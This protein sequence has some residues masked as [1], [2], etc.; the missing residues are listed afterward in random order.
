MYNLNEVIE[1][2]LEELLKDREALALRNTTLAEAYHQK[3][4]KH[5]MRRLLLNFLAGVYVP[6]TRKATQTNRIL[7]IRPDHLGDLLL[8][9]PAIQALRSHLPDAEIHALVGP[10]AADVLTNYDEIDLVLTIP[11]PGFTRGQQTNWRSPYQYALQTAQRLRRIGYAKAIVF[12]PDH[13]W[14][15]WLAK[16]A[17][18]PVRVGYDD[19]DTKLFLT[20]ELAHQH[21]HAVKQNMRLVEALIGTSLSTHQAPLNYPV[22]DVDTAYITGYLSE[23]NIH[24][25]QPI[26]CIHPGSGTK[27]KQWQATKWAEVATILTEQF[28]A[29]VVFTG[30]D[31]ELP[32]IQEITRHMA[33][34]AI[35]IAG[36]TNVGQ[37]AALYQRSKVVLGPDSGPLHVA[38]GVGTP[39]VTLY[40][41]AD[42]VEFGSWGDPQRHITLHTNIACRP[43]RILD[44]SSDDIRYHPCVQDITVTQ[45]LTAARNAAAHSN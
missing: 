22:V 27:V 31:S 2:P 25:E 29:T 13:W 7:L 37:L 35:V 24:K 20:H 16:L 18:I 1:K 17:G 41:P 32:I 3:P 39:T 38:V 4:F 19:E 33:A 21:D 45:V 11:F 8:T 40:G 14:G 30:S 6:H 36:D 44:W 42:P 9:T 5:R 28:N 10:W 26:F 15:A 34:P 23:W 12:R 43:C